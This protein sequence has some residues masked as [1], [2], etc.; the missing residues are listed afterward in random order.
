MNVTSRSF[1]ALLIVLCIT[2]QVTAPAAQAADWHATGTNGAV[3][4]GEP[5]SVDAGI[6]ILRAGG[7]AA[8]AAVAT[9]LA[10][11]LT[12]GALFCLGGEV[13]IMVYDAKRGVVE[14]LVGQGT[15]PRLATREYFAARGEI[16]ARGIE[17]A[18]V[19]AALDAC[20]TL[21]DRYGSKSFA[22]VAAPTLALLER[23]SAD[24]HRRYHKTLSRLCEA[25]ANGARGDRSRGL[26]SVADYFYRGPIAR[27]IDAWSQSKG[28]LLRYSDLATHSTRIE[29]P[30]SID[31]HGTT[32]LK[33]GA[34]TQGPYLLETLRLLE[35]FD[36]RSIGHNQPD[37]IH[38]TIEA[39]KLA[40]ADR[41]LYYA[42]PRFADVPLD[43]LLSVAYA[44]LRRPLI[45]RAAASQLQRPGNPRAMQPL[46]SQAASTGPGG[47][48]SDTTTCLVADSAGNVVAATP[49]GWS[50]VEA[51]D[52]GVWLG[53]RLQ[54]FTLDA[55]SPNVI[56]PGKMPRIT[57]SPTLVL[58]DG[59]P[60]MA[61]SVAGGD[62]QDQATLQVLMNVVDYGISAG[63][64]VTA[65][66]FGTNHH[67]GS[68]RQSAP[69]LG[70]LLLYEEVGAPT[71]EELRKRGHRVQISKPPLWAPSVIVLDPA[72]RKFDAAGDPAARRHAAA[73]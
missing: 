36:L 69:E 2:A 15:A 73:Y 19:P 23:A 20:L 47:P 32:V 38:T 52:T 44:D 37:S 29:D 9:I 17:A 54:S 56:E 14:V 71:A 5:G 41:D 61:I 50:G 45:D 48:A 1:A 30:V 12:D 66:R 58:R 42:D 40:L 51:A 34:W 21:L 55:K 53:S 57:L 22:E 24:R 10:L 7:N 31:Y 67:V 8:D 13:P 16:P 72:G 35:P 4:S 3:S 43:A 65:P 28:G 49:S 33:C 27:E 62:G 60:A 59:R 25:E 18:T 46:L 6:T 63:K 68:F 26:R 39:M 11:A 70:S 64:A